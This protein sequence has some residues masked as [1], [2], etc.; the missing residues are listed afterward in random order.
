MIKVFNYISRK[1]IGLNLYDNQVQRQQRIALPF[2]TN[3]NDCSGMLDS[4]G[5]RNLYA[6]KIEDGFVKNDNG[7]ISHFMNV[8]TIGDSLT[9]ERHHIKLSDGVMLN[10]SYFDGP[11]ISERIGEVVKV[12]IGGEEVALNLYKDAPTTITLETPV[13]YFNHNWMG[14]Y[15][16]TVIETMSKFYL[17]EKSNL[18]LK[19]PILYSA[20][21]KY[22]LDLFDMLNC[23]KNDLI[24][25]KD[26][27]IKYRDMIFPSMADADGLSGDYVNWLRS[28]LAKASRAKKRRIYLTRED[29]AHKKVLNE[30]AVFELLKKYGFIKIKFENLTVAEQIRLMSE[31]DIIVAPHGAGLANVIF[32]DDLKVIEFSLDVTP[33]P[34]YWWISDWLGHTYCQI[35]CRTDEFY[36]IDVPI[37]DLKMA[38]D[39]T[40]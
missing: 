31:T 30:Y 36:N 8:E 25:I 7:F 15:A 34:M 24:N 9:K 33:H 4:N 14:N 16:H 10:E 37:A 40:L 2:F 19:F 1:N 11:W 3:R 17:L 20:S 28:K 23:G 32:G 12:N 18:Q 38:L 27:N 29:A 22:Q 35:V 5:A 6:Y 13:I 39:V 26:N 21:A